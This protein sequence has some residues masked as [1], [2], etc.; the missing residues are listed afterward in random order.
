MPLDTVNVPVPA[1]ALA[2]LNDVLPVMVPS[3]TETVFVPAKL[4][5]IVAVNVA[6]D[7]LVIGT[8]APPLSEYTS[9]GAVVYPVRNPVSVNGVPATALV[10]AFGVIAFVTSGTCPLRVTTDGLA[11]M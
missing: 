10:G 6:G 3:V 7:T 9:V 4:D 11:A 8:P 2:T 1:V 5:V